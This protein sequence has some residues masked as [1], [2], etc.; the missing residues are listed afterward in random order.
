[1]IA[2]PTTDAAR[3]LAAWR[4]LAPSAEH[5]GTCATTPP[6]VRV[7]WPAGRMLGAS[8]RQAIAETTR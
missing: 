5:V 3:A 2:T 4:R 7:E 6:G 8:V 1:M